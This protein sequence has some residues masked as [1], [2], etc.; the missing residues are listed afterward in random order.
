M[1]P[2]K[3][4]ETSAPRRTR[5]RKEGEVGAGV[6]RI[7]APVRPANQ[8]SPRN[9]TGQP[10]TLPQGLVATAA[11]PLVGPHPGTSSAPKCRTAMSSM[12]TVQ[13]PRRTPPRIHR[14]EVSGIE[15]KVLV[16]LRFALIRRF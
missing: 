5:R 3:P 15:P 7:H 9:D 4:T 10:S 12:E 16:L 2:R 6:K 13:T 8:A 14:G 1:S 11:Q